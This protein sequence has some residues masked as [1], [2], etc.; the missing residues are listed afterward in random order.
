MGGVIGEAM[1]AALHEIPSPHAW[2]ARTFACGWTL[3]TVIEISVRVRPVCW[4]SIH[5]GNNLLANWRW[6]H[7]TRRRK[8]SARYIL[9]AQVWFIVCKLAPQTRCHFNYAPPRIQFIINPRQ[10][11]LKKEIKPK[12]LLQ[13]WNPDEVTA[14]WQ[15]TAAMRK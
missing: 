7:V 11:Q 4:L 13:Q 3:A 5:L 2:V 8:V 9:P 10:A 15:R 14:K 1:P 6:K 12:T